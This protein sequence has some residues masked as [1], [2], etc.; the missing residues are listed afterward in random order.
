MSPANRAGIG[1]CDQLNCPGP[2]VVASSGPNPSATLHE[3]RSAQLPRMNNGIQAAVHS[4]SFKVLA[5]LALGCRRTGFCRVR[6][7][8]N[9]DK[10]LLN[11]GGIPVRSYGWQSESLLLEYC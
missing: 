7:G 11:F 3:D 6:F 1:T 2:V 9:D 10:T 8:Q 4:S 5:E